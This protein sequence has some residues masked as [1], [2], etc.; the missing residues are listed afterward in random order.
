[1][2]NASPQSDDDYGRGN[3]YEGPPTDRVCRCTHIYAQ[4]VDDDAQ[5]TLVTASSVSKEIRDEIGSTGT[6]ETA[7]AVGKLLAKRALERN[8]HKLVFDRGGH[9]YHGR[10]KALAD[11]VREAG[12]EF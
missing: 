12:I 9:I 8:I 10:L 5:Q 1:M 11:A 7:R 3:G 2:Q 4:V 6:I